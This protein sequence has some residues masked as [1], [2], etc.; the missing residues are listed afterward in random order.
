MARAHP[1]TGPSLTI[2]ITLLAFL[3]PAPAGPLWLYGGV[4]LAALITGAL[5]APWHGALICLPLW[6]FLFLL[7]GVLGAD[8]SWS[9]GSL[10][11]SRE[12]T[13]MALGQ[14]ARLGA[15]VTATLA[16]YR[17]FSVPRFVDAASE[18]GWPFQYSYLLVA[19][20]MAV[21]R[22]VSQV[23]H[24]RE[25]QRT[26]GLR[27]TGNWLTKGRGLKALALP[28]AFGALAEAEERALALETRS[29]RAP[30][31]RTPLHVVQDRFAD[32]LARWL[33]WSSVVA[34]VVWRLAS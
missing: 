33:G 25:A 30:V 22:F 7:H 1:F 10:S 27:L 5:S 24:I 17:G 16:M 12:G 28:L 19:T 15:I 26:R 4:V 11:L 13:A 8:P 34:A 14:A 23:H 3:L 9:L 20:I 18:R 29:I 2:A 6:F 21:P 32:R 31:R